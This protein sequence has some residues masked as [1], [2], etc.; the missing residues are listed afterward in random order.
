MTAK[1]EAEKKFQL[2]QKLNRLVQT[3]EKV[4]SSIAKRLVPLTLTV[5]EKQKKNVTKKARIMYVRRMFITD[6]LFF[7]S[8]L[9]ESV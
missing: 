8:I 3:T 9:F 5:I 1:V 7:P 4:Q 6:N 2:S